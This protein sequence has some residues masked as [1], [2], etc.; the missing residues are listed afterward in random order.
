MEITDTNVPCN[1]SSYVSFADLSL[2]RSDI[3]SSLLSLENI[4]NGYFLRNIT[5]YTQQQFCSKI[6][7]KKA[8]FRKIALYET[9][10]IYFS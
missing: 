8:L 5:F 9:L 10:N 2:L 3:H 6:T 7:I 4:Y 1:L